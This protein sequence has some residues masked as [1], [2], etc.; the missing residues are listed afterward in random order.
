MK[1]ECMD[2]PGLISALAFAAARHGGQK[3]L[4]KGGM[5]YINHPIDVADILCRIGGVE[6]LTILAAAFLHDV[7]EDTDTSPE[8]IRGL[9]GD[10]V[11]SIVMEVSDEK[12]VSRERKRQLQLEHVPHLSHAAKLIKIADKISNTRDLSNDPPVKWTVSDICEYRK[13]AKRV[14]DLLRGTNKAMEEYFDKMGNN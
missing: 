13:F 7:I 11:Y 2:I 4:G 5:P 6:D 10:E 8:E 12:G 3:R 1:Q 9:F 14:V